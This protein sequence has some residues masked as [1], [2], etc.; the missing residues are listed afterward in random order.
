MGHSA[1][2][3]RPGKLLVRRDL[4]E[5]RIALHSLFLVFPRHSLVTFPACWREN[6]LTLPPP[7]CLHL[8]NIDEE[9]LVRRRPAIYFLRRVELLFLDYQFVARQFSSI[10]RIH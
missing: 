5:T 9:Q 1:S 2:T 4:R 7:Q 8:E 6:D 3:L 10:F